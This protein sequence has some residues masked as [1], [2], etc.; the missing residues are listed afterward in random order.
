[1][2]YSEKRLTFVPQK[3]KIS[4]NHMKIFR[5]LI[6]VILPIICQAQT[7]EEALGYGLPVV[8]INTVNGEEPTAERI[9]APAGCLGSS[10]INATKV[11]GR[12]RIYNPGDAG[13]PV[14]DSGEYAEDASGMVFKI[15]GNTSALDSKKPFKIKL[16]K[17]ADMLMRGDKKFNDRD[18]ALI[19][20]PGS[21]KHLCP[22]ITM[23]GNKVTEIL[24]VSG[25]IPAG[26]Y[27]NLIVND[28]F[29]G[30]YYLTET[31]KR[32]EKCR[33]DVEE[34]TGYISEVDPYWWNEDIYVESSL[35]RQMTNAYKFTFKYPDSDEITQEQLDTFKGY[36]DQLDA[37]IATGGYPCYIDV[38]SCARWLLAHQLL[39]SKDGAG[40]N[41]YLIRRDGQSELEMG[42]LWDFDSSFGIQGS[43]TPIMTMHYFK[44]MLQNSP[45]KVL[46]REMIRIWESEKERIMAEISG[47]C[48]S[49]VGTELA[50]AIDMSTEANLKR[51]HG[52]TLDDME[53]TI[54][55]LRQWFPVRAEDMD[56]LLPTLSINDGA[57]QWNNLPEGT[58][59]LHGTENPVAG[60]TLSFSTSWN[61]LSQLAF[62]WTR[63]DALGNFN[64]A[65][66]LSADSAYIV[67]D[68]DYEHWLR[69]TIHDRAGNIVYTKDTWIS[70]LPVLYIDTEDSK[71]I[72]SKT[73]YV[74]ANI[75][76]Q[77]NADF[78]QQYNDTVEI[79]GRGTTSWDQYPQKPYKL[80]LRKKANLFGF[81]KGKHWVL[82]PNFNDKSCLRNYIASE[83]AKQLGVMG[84]N[85]TWV[86]VVINGEVKGCYM[87]SQHIR[88][89]K[90]SVDIFDWEGEAEDVADAL[91]AAV[92]DADDQ[93][94]TD[95]EL[96]EETMAQNLAWVTDGMVTFKGKTY[97]LADYGLK[98]EYDISQGFLFEATAKKDG[99]TQFTTP[100]N[101]HFEVSTPEYLSTNSEMMTYVT[102]F[103]KDFEAAYSR[104]PSEEC[105]NFQRYANMKTMVGVW[106]V[107]EIMGQGDP[108]NSRYSYIDSSGK[109]N[110][111]PVWDFDHAG[112]CW[113]T[114]HNVNFFY[115]LIHKLEYIYYKKW[116]PDP[117]L[118]QMAYDAY[119]EVARPFM[120]DYI[121]EGGDMDAKYAFFTE[122]G[123]TNDI[124]WGNYPSKL[125]PSATP[126]TTAEDVEILRT[127]LLGHIE[128][129]DGK[130]QSVRTLIEA[131]NVYSAY[132]CDPNA[133][134]IPDV[135]EED[136]RTGTR[137]EIRDKRLYIIRNDE[138]YSVDG[139]KIK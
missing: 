88:V 108:T 124:L 10:I 117:V 90:N 50:Q 37:S 96:L 54:E 4:G 73:N 101:V 48:E 16:Q 113:T 12:V 8:V 14:F 19:R 70:K 78:E 43:F 77:G 105:K 85:M 87:L 5:F 104:D 13:N 123:K 93:I 98:K 92:K 129:L 46:A 61:D 11:P 79:R 120:M 22:I 64:E 41:L 34:A 135:V 62:K 27:V 109:L 116:F 136:K 60:S 91:F 52:N 39:G 23:V 29:R 114:D 24:K 47:F 18:W 15:R 99:K 7:L 125:N 67:T 38:E 81:G 95:K 44:Q 25:W 53:T 68:S 126:R 74:T 102:N 59:V 127:F 130:F 75:R 32:N 112:A 20:P 30:F 31:V 69:A 49:L 100:G 57:I 1:M 33:I 122:A 111:G 106:L 2:S 83:L 3:C 40:S 72:T 121:S 115:T 89:D 133:V 94:E 84:M 56:N 103:W 119:W 17:K 134:G 36:I 45:N 118:C 82:I 58:F 138:T 9:D 66:V 55:K 71:P 76:I 137:K 65:D 107:N 42:P 139:K 110:F 28:N 132:P 80:K 131:M 97:N 35:I 128:W 63:G 21:Y 26:E 86:D 51:W 6:M